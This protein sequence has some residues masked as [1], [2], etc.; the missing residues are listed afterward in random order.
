[1]STWY[2]RLVKGTIN[3]IYDPGKK[4]VHSFKSS[5]K[6]FRKN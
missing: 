5:Y 1:M 3:K 4:N 2:L 6:T